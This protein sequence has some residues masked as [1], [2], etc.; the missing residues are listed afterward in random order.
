MTAPVPPPIGA[1]P[2]VPSSLDPEATFD[3]QWEAFNRWIAD[4]LRPGVNAAA[5]AVGD[6]ATAAAAAAQQA[7]ASAVD[8]HQ[9]A[10]AAAASAE[11]AGEASGATAWNAATAYT[12]G[13][14]VFIA[15]S[16]GGLTYRR[17]TDGTSATPPDQDATNWQV[18]VSPATRPVVTSTHA[19]NGVPLTAGT[20]YKLRAQ[21]AYSRPLPVAPADGAEIVLINSHNEW[22]GNFTLTRP[23]GH[24][25]NGVADNL[26]FAPNSAKTVTAKFVAPSNWVIT[27]Q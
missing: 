13:Q 26:S 6:N 8:A 7:G 19:D 1:A 23:T 5:T 10:A 11:A 3:A 25:L 14:R 15:G 12:I 24:T 4:D 2:P 22:G 20:D 21:S 9:A 16:G 17:Q 27:A 18:V